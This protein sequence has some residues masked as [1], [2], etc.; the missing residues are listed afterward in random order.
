MLFSSLLWIIHLAVAIAAK[1]NKSLK[2]MI[3]VR[4]HAYVIMTKDAKIG[5]RFIFKNGSYSSDK[6]LTGYD[7]ALVFENA[8]VGFKTLAFGGDTGIDDARNNWNLRILGD[9]YHMLW[10]GVVM[11]MALGGIKRK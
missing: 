3:K 9:D 10:F 4:N 7:M 2:E 6:V 8:S 5:R 1:R 11:Q